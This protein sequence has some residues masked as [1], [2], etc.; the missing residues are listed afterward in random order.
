[1]PGR[2]CLDALI[3]KE[4]YDNLAVSACCLPG[5]QIY[6]KK[7]LAPAL[8]LPFQLYLQGVPLAQKEA[9]DFLLGGFGARRRRRLARNVSYLAA[10]SLL[11]CV[12][13]FYYV[14]SHEKCLLSL[15]T[16]LGIPRF[17]GAEPLGRGDSK[18]RPHARR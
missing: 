3:L 6:V 15:P 10:R 16:A 8:Y 7:H 18:K 9:I 14:L 11:L 13:P 17:R 1:L 5:P 4:P 12:A 2:Y